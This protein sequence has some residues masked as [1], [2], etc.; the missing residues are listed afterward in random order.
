MFILCYSLVTLSFECKNEQIN[1]WY[2]QSFYRA[3]GI[4]GIPRDLA[5]KKDAN[6]RK[7]STKQKVDESGISEWGNL[8]ILLP[9]VFEYIEYRCWPRELKHLSN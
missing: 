5:A 2:T 8:V 4:W 6:M 3:Q 1:C 9:S 7:V